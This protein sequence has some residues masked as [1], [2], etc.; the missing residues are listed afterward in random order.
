MMLT[1]NHHLSTQQIEIT[2]SIQ[3]PFLQLSKGI[4]YSIFLLPLPTEPDSHPGPHSTSPVL[5]QQSWCVPFNR[6]S[7][8]FLSPIVLL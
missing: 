3:V 5:S 7:I 4:D 6:T 1:G 8:Y 2:F